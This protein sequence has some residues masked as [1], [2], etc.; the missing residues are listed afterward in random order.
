MQGAR[1]IHVVFL[2]AVPLAI[3]AFVVTWFLPEKELR[4]TAHVGAVE[5]GGGLLAGF[6]LIDPE[7]APELV[8]DAEEEH[9]PQAR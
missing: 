6:G 9:S 7:T 5:A 4:E 3:A 1:S 8:V 2:C